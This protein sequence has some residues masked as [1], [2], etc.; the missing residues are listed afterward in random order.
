MMSGMMMTLLQAGL[1]QK[2]V[3]AGGKR[4]GK[5]PSLEAS[6]IPSQPAALQPKALFTASVL[7]STALPCLLTQETLNQKAKSTAHI[8]RFTMVDSHIRWHIV[9]S[10]PLYQHFFPKPLAVSSP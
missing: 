9:A 4:L 5:G 1:S 8:L 3:T 10:L 2:D 6:K 7:D